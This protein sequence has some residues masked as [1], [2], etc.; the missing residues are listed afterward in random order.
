MLIP[1]TGHCKRI[2]SNCR[3]LQ[4]LAAQM[5]GY[6]YTFLLCSRPALS[7]ERWTTWC[8]SALLPACGQHDKWM[9]TGYS[10]ISACLAQFS[11]W[12]HCEFNAMLSLG[13]LSFQSNVA[14]HLRTLGFKSTMVTCTSGPVE[15]SAR[16]KTSRHSGKNNQTYKSK[17]QTWQ[18]CLFC[19]GFSSAS[20]QGCTFA[21]TKN[22]GEIV[23]TY[24]RLAQCAFLSHAHRHTP[25][26]GEDWH[27]AGSS[28]EVLVR[29]SQAWF[30]TT[31]YDDPTSSPWIGHNHLFYRWRSLWDYFGGQACQSWR[32]RQSAQA[33]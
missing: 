31:G 16:G 1:N 3:S 15:R 21:S 12:T 30:V 23:R 26:G 29:A 22:S 17:L 19:L 2:Y 11:R 8:R 20:C 9:T 7:A 27:P 10:S 25:F 5:Q 6:W 28:S 18:T 13:S 32:V 24:L 14:S 4:G 33:A